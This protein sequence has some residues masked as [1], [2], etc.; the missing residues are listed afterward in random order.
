MRRR[1]VSAVLLVAVVLLGPS[2][3]TAAGASTAV[4]VSVGSVD[5][6]AAPGPMTAYVPVTL[7]GPAPG[8][9]SVSY[10]VVGR[11]A[12]VGRD[13]AAD[14]GT[15]TVSTGSVAVE[16]PVHVMAAAPGPAP[17]CFFSSGLPCRTFE[18]AVSVTGPASLAPGA[19]T[20]SILLGGTK[21]NGGTIAIGDVSLTVPRSGPR[22]TVAL[23]ISWRPPRTGSP[24]LPFSYW[25]SPASTG[26]AFAGPATLAPAPSPP[27]AI[28]LDVTPR[29][30]GAQVEAVR[31]SEGANLAAVRPTGQLTLLSPGSPLL[32]SRGLTGFA[33]APLTQDTSPATGLGDVFNVDWNG[34]AASIAAPR[35]NIGDNS[36]SAFWPASESPGLANEACATWLAQSPAQG[37]S[38]VT[39]QGLSF[40]VRTEDGV[41]RGITLTKNVYEYLN[42][43]FNV[44]VWDT[45]TTAVYALV[46]KFNLAGSL[47]LTLP[48]DVCAR[49]V[50]RQLS[51]IA[52]PRGAP[53]PPWGSTTRG[54]AVT[55]PG[56]FVAPGEDGFY[57][58]HLRPGASMALANLVVGPGPLR[59]DGRTI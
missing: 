6:V 35:A 11:S 3:V 5:V 18:L 54:G 12:L 44:H 7:S 46:G 4:T 42:R 57:V 15:R 13:L 27:A 41:T 21:W 51:F 49:I 26:G 34:A 33:A 9:V 58:G 8:P 47:P 25:P 28:A 19:S 55:L 40:D 53:P 39:Q 10:R 20:D 22:F 2:S 43:E 50:G 14:A 1:L 38:V 37:L 29:A 16:I 32:V 52:W 36:R 59:F 31:V 30:R 45:S 56:A 17:A 48:W 24:M 23:P